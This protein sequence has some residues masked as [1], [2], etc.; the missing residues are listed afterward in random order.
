MKRIIKSFLFVSMLMS[1]SVFAAKPPKNKITQNKA[2]KLALKEAP[3]K[4]KSSEL[5]FE[6]G[7]W[8]YSFDIISNGEIH[9][10][11]IDAVTSKIVSNKIETAEEEAAEE[12]AEALKKK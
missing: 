4:I 6:N 9:E 12:K 8:V 2:E 10:V 7:K 5:E 1:A 11:Q 3:G